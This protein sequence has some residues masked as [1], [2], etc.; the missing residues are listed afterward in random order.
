[1]NRDLTFILVSTPSSM[2]SKH[3]HKLL[4]LA[5][6]MEGL[7]GGWSTLQSTTS[8]YISDCTSP[9]SRAQ[10]FSRFTGVFSVGFAA[11]P[12]IGGWLI[13]ESAVWGPM[14]G[15]S[16][17]RTVTFVFWTAICSSL[18]NLFLVLLIFPESLTKE[19]RAN[20]V[21]EHWKK[22]ERPDLKVDVKGKQKM[23][24][25]LPS[26]MDEC[27]VGTDLV[28]MGA[29]EEESL[30]SSSSVARVS[31]KGKASS[32]DEER[33]LI[34]NLLGPIAV[35]LPM[36]VYEPSWTG[37]GFKKRVDWSITTLAVAL[38]GLMLSMVSLCLIRYDDKH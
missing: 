30:P 10:I 2:M 6:I 28:G 20:V 16:H 27:E 25:L 29:E 36:A 26:A 8:A 1:M 31:F 33:G 13:S 7:L 38:F 19:K 21:N 32:S 3:G 18:V 34:S 11:G 23:A 35:F 17:E 14:F 12:A 9:G 5:P 4:I 24:I 22:L 37:V 15:A